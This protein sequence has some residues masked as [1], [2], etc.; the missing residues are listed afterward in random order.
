M[1]SLIFLKA[2]SEGFLGARLS[3]MYPLLTASLMSLMV[4][5]VL[6][7]KYVGIIPFIV[8]MCSVN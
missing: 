2:S 1:I 8:T 5:P 4:Y 3:S 7:A 6:S